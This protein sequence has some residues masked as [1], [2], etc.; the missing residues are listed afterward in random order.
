MTRPKTALLA[1][2]LAATALAPAAPAHASGAIG[3][4]MTG[5]CASWEFDVSGPLPEGDGPAAYLPCGS[6]FAIVISCI[7]SDFIAGL[8]Y[9]GDDGG[10]TGYRLFRFATGGANI[11]VHLRQEGI[12][13]AW[14]GYS[15]FD[16][17]LYVALQAERGSLAITDTVTGKVTTLPLTGANGAIADL[18][19]YC[20]T[21]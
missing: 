6:D 2:L 17:P 20:A 12:D 8:R 4:D 18:R 3:G 11:E 14:A 1:C 19:S 13:L 7:L 16:H 10:A 5:A 9:Y 15:E 21:M